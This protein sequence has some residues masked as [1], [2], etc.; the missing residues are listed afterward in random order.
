MLQ[1]SSYVILRV[2]NGRGAMTKSQLYVVHHR[3]I[4]QLQDYAY[5]LHRR[6]RYLQKRGYIMSIPS[7][8][9][10]RIIILTE[11]GKK[12]FEKVDTEKMHQHLTRCRL[13]KQLIELGHSGQAEI[14]FD[15]L[16]QEDLKK[17]F[18]DA[19]TDLLFFERRIQH[20]GR[21]YELHISLITQLAERH[22]IPIDMEYAS[23]RAEQMFESSLGLQIRLSKPK[24][25]RKC[26]FCGYQCANEQALT[27]RR[28]LEKYTGQ[29]SEV[30][31]CSC[32]AHLSW[33]EKHPEVSK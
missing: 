20:A 32:F 2:L 13:E 12:A 27:D 8:K 11:K 16:S 23:R 22:N 14:D 10:Q 9:L 6:L 5:D 15:N 29:T 31:C 7:V 19:L 17:V 18:E 26:Y 3:E 33:L 4:E 21:T 1:P 24:E 30:V 25:Y 28:L